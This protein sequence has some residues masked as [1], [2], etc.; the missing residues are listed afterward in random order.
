MIVLVIWGALV[1]VVGVE[2]EVVEI[3]TVVSACV[4]EDAA[5]VL[6]RSDTSPPHDA[7]ASAPTTISIQSLRMTTPQVARTGARRRRA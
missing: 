6:D 4:V 3:G 1:V 5:V 2:V 7:A